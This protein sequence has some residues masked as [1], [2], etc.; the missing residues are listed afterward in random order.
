MPHGVW[1]K[2]MFDELIDLKN[3]KN[4]IPVLAHIDRYGFITKAN[5]KLIDYYLE[6]GGLIQANTYSLYKFLSRKKFLS[7]LEKNKVHFLG[8]DSHNLTTRKPDFDIALNYLKKN[9][10]KTISKIQN[11]EK[12]ITFFNGGNI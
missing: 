5:A 2:R 1:T 10:Q 12:I 9:Y 7:L 3:S 4:V 6:N 11:N 8:T